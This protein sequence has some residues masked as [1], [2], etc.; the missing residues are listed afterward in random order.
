MLTFMASFQSSWQNVIDG[1][2]VSISITGMVIVFSSLAIISAF[3]A[4]VPHILVVVNKFFPEAQ[5]A[6]KKKAAPVAG[7]SDDIVA[8]IGVAL[9]CTLQPS[10]NQ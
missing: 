1:H 2:G 5:E 7:V 3:I 6:P 8:A 4:L 9:H 10:Q